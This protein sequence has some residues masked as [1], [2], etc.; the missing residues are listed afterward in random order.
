MFRHPNLKH[1]N[2]TTDDFAKEQKIDQSIRYL[3]VPA[4]KAKAD[5]LNFLLQ[6]I[7]EHSSVRMH[8]GKVRKLYYQLGSAAAAILVLFT[9]YFSFGFEEYTGSSSAANVFFLPDNSRVVLDENATISY[10]KLFF[11]RNVKVEGK[12]Y[13]EVE[14]GSDFYVKTR[15]GSITVFGTRFSVN[16][17]NKALKVHCY[18]GIVGVDYANKRIKLEGGMQMYGENSSFTIKKNQSVDY[19]S[20]ARFSFNCNNMPLQE[21]WPVVENF[22]GL[23]IVSNQPLDKSFTGSINTGNIN[24]VMEIICTSMDLN[25]EIKDGKIILEQN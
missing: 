8:R 17:L 6:E 24:E 4:V 5:V 15:N 2:G 1:R 9:L 23:D 7:N 14:S 22:F 3:Q 25:F 13:F 18:E 11:K 19:P 12:A 20:F 16:D 10:S 21:V